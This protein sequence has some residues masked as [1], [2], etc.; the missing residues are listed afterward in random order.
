[1]TDTSLVSSLEDAE[2]RLRLLIAKAAVAANP[3]QL[4]QLVRWL[5]EVQRIVA[6]ASSSVGGNFK[7]AVSVDARSASEHRSPPLAARVKNQAVAYPFFIRNGEHL[8]KVAWSKASKNEYEHKAPKTVMLTLVASLAASRG[9]KRIVLEKMLP[10]K[11]AVSGAA[12]PD[13]QIYVVLAWLRNVGL[14]V[15]HGRQGYTLAG[16][17]LPEKAQASWEQLPER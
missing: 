17:D 1:M 4:N 12:F 13:Y 7:A 9:G 11:D 2:Q 10:L 15:Q 5:S 6:E 16:G 8:V 14:V 3:D